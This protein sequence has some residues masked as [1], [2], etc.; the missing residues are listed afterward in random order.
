M[1]LGPT[2][3]STRRRSTSLGPLD[4]VNDAGA[5]LRVGE[6]GH[7]LVDQLL[8]NRKTVVGHHEKVA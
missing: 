6:D 7:R 2:W 4:V 8:I 5:D 3:G 1:S